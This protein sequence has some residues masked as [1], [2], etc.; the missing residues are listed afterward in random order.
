LQKSVAVLG[1]IQE[2][3]L[4]SDEEFALTRADAG[5]GIVGWIDDL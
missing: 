1:D 5:S 3:D 2:S 4:V